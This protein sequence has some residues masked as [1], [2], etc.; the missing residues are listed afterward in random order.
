MSSSHFETAE[1]V[2]RYPLHNSARAEL[3]L[4]TDLRAC[5]RARA[6]SRALP[7]SHRCQPL[8]GLRGDPEAL[9]VHQV[10]KCR[11]GTSTLYA[12]HHRVFDRDFP[13]ITPDLR[14]HASRARLERCEG[15]GRSLRSCGSMVRG[16]GYRL[17]K[18]QRP[19]R[20]LVT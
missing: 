11:Y 17:S 19:H 9:H 2:R 18:S 1:F 20:Q 3:S 5:P 13:G 6:G 16:C 12:F 4:S 8:P 7:F 14:V 10:T 15:E